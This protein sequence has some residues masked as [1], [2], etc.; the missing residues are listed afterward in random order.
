MALILTGL[1]G[2]A[3]LKSL[4]AQR[5]KDVVEKIAIANVEIAAPAHSTRSL[6]DISTCGSGKI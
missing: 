5:A 1:A 6:A 3:C 4:H 2:L